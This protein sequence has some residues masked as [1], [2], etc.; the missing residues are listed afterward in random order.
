MKFTYVGTAEELVKESV[1][2]EDAAEIAVDIECE[3]NLHHYG[4]YISLIQ[5]STKKGSWVIDVLKLKEIKP[6]MRVLED[7]KVEKIFHDVSFDF[8]IL[9]SKYGVQPKP[10]FDTQIAAL[11]LG[12]KEVGLG[13]LLKEYFGLEKEAKFQMADW[14]KRPLSPEMLNYAVTDTLHLIPLRDRLR[15]EL[16]EKGRYEWFKQECAYVESKGVPYQEGDFS[17]LKGYALLTDQQRAILKRLFFVR[18]ALAREADR[19]VH[20]IFSNKRLLEFVEHP[21]SLDQLRRLTGV[22]HL[23]RQRIVLL[24]KAIEQGKKESLAVVRRERQHSTAAQKESMNVL[25]GLRDLIAE[26]LGL[27][28]YLILSKE[29]V[30]SIVLMGSSCLRPWQKK[31]LEE[32]G[33]IF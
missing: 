24:S 7:P 18:D 9:L 6:L 23:V 33:A 16:Q 12:K 31:L 30:E 3:N 19:P 17:D 26:K 1:Y 14:T 27:Q 4:T 5:I 32:H 10:L 28:K 2:W 20:F 25:L 21:P 15:K 13:A 29:Q 11:L 8:R 22:H